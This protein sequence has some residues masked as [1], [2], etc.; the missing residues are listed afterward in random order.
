M[1]SYDDVYKKAK[2]YVKKSLEGQNLDE[3]F[4]L[5]FPNWGAKLLGSSRLQKKSWQ[6][7]MLAAPGLC[8]RFNC[9]AKG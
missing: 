4:E 1:L 7:Q 3:E 8:N 6:A 2:I 9:A 5:L